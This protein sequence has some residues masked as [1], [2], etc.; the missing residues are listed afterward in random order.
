MYALVSL[1]RDESCM[2]GRSTG[3][4][5]IM[6]TSSGEGFY[7]FGTYVFS[8]PYNFFLHKYSKEGSGQFYIYYEL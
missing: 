3:V 5:T 6:K 7:A 8:E 1:N 4:Y 2:S